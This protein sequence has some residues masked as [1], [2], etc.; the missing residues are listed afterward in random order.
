MN[1]EILKGNWQQMKGKVKEHWGKL[2]DDE[3]TQIDGN[4]DQL[5]GKIK[6]TYGQN[7]EEAQNSVDELLKKSDGESA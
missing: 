3:I 2:T 4:Y 5:V 6:E 7:L 1:K